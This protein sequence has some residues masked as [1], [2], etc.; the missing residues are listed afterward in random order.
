MALVELP[1]VV[2]NP[3]LP[4][5]FLES[6]RIVNANEAEHAVAL[7]GKRR[8]GREHKK[9]GMKSGDIVRKWK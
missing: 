2:E 4:Y 6:N 7:V 1:V 9:I 3:S 8:V 5:M